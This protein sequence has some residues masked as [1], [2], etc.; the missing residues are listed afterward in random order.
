MFFIFKLMVN[1]GIAT[2]FCDNLPNGCPNVAP[3]ILKNY[4]AN[5]SVITR[6]TK[7]WWVDIDKNNILEGDTDYEVYGDIYDPNNWKVIENP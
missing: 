2:I 3:N 4:P 6:G 1:Y 7:E 5:R